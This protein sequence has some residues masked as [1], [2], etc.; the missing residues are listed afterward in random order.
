MLAMLLPNA[1]H[2]SLDLGRRLRPQADAPEFGKGIGRVDDEGDGQGL[3]ASLP[4][5]LGS[6]AEFGFVGYRT[7]RFAMAALAWWLH[8]VD[9]F[10]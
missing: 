10:A 2:A 6:G 5:S 8:V 9:P 7:L 4:A 1:V 3:E